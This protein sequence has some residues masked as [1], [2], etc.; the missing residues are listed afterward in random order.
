MDILGETDEKRQR[1]PPNLEQKELEMEGR[2]YSKGWAMPRPQRALTSL[3]GKPLVE[4]AAK[5]R[6]AGEKRLRDIL[7]AVRACPPGK[8]PTM[9][10]MHKHII[11]DA[12]KREVRRGKREVG[13]D[14]GAADDRVGGEGAAIE[15]GGGAAAAAGVEI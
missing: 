1:T 5:Y 6:D 4:G 11:S 8:E 2:I 3:G 13:E 7:D 15:G 9:P 14:A 12:E 10:T